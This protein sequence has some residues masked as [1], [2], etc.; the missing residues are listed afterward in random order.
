MT[1]HDDSHCACVARNAKECMRRR[2]RLEDYDDFE[3]CECCCHDED[4]DEI[5]PW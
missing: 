1:G 2:Y 3:P 4:E 5:N